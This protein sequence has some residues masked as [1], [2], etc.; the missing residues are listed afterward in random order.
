MYIVKG[1][2]ILV[3]FLFCCIE[4]GKLWHRTGSYLEAALLGLSTMMAIFNVFCV[5]FHFMQVS[6][7]ILTVLF[8][9]ILGG[10]VVLSVVLSIRMK[11]K[12]TLFSF[13]PSFQLFFVLALALIG[14]QIFRLVAY[15][16]VIYGDDVTYISMI[17]DIKNTGLIQGL[18]TKTGEVTPPWS[19]KYMLTSYY[20]FLAYW[21]TIF[22]F[23]PLLFF[24]TFFPVL[25]T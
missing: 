25:T 10:L 5:P 7:R 11:K 1:I 16:P 2:F 3:F 6:F 14:F 22:D 21:C 12:Y 17:N 18:L 24:K 13:R 15:Q 19:S 23:H 8:S 4:V 20:P 9:V